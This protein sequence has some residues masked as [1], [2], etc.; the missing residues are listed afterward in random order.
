MR[1]RPL[2]LAL[3]VLVPVSAAVWWFGR[4]APVASDDARVGQ[5]VADPAALA[6]AA[7]VTIKSSGKSVELARGDGDRWTLVGDPVLPADTSRLT[8]LTADLVAP[9]IERHVSSLADKIATFELDSAGLVYADA[10]GKPLLDLD[11]GKTLEGGARVV[12]YGDEQKTYAARLGVHLDAEPSSWRDTTLVAGLQASDIASISIGFPDTPAPVVVSRPKAEDP[13]TS[14]ATPA[15][16]QVKASL[17]TS[18]IGNLSGLRYTDVA[19][20]LDPGVVA[21]RIFPREVTLGTFDGRTVK[22][23]FARAP[24]PPAPPAPEVKEGETP[25]PPPAAAPR[26]AYVEITD[27]KPD[28]ILAAA[29]K[30]HAFEVAE[31]IFTALPAKTA[32]LFEPVPTPPAPSA[33]TGGSSPAPA[34]SPDTGSSVSVTTPPLTVPAPTPEPP[35]EPAP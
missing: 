10:S 19:P 30:T 29:A 31:W 15:G 24:E 1:L 6:S 25:P 4:P 11:L 35:A 28:A 17:I 34:T 9:K 32:D 18:Q 27:S 14:P 21:A 8:R 33:A 16:Q 13:W 12:R 23:A 5:R 7:R 26:P 22:I 3:A 20:N 2:L